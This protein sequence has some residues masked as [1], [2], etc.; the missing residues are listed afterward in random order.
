MARRKR[1]SP[2]LEAAHHR[3][4]GL[5]SI[6]P[7]PDFGSTL[8]IPAYTSQISDFGAKLDH[9]NQMI[10]TLDDLQLQLERAE[11][12]LRETN[13]R[14]LT[15]TQAQYGTNSSQYQQVG[16]KHLSERKRQT[17]RAVPTPVS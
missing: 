16:S 9:Y 1:N 6:T 17:R 14:M 5:N 3:L 11:A 4:A 2:V 7:S 15:A 13:K 12:S 8:T 10:A